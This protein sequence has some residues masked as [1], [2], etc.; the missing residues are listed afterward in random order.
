MN[1]AD[2]AVL[3]IDACDFAL[4][5]QI[6]ATIRGTARVS[7]GHRVVPRRAAARM[8]QAAIDRK[9]HIVE[10]QIGQMF[11]HAVAIQ[12]HGIIALIDHRI[13]APRKGVALAVGMEQVDQTALRMHHVVV[14]VFFKTLPQLQRMGIEF[15]IPLKKV[16]RP[17]DG[18]VA[19]DITPAKVALF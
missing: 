6:D 16:I 14:Q 15:G 5:D 19:A 13:A 11:A 17:H 2:L 9:P 3:D 1:T 12:Q 8:Q 10:I 7:P 18:R 4:L